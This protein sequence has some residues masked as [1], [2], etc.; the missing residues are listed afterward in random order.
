MRYADDGVHADRICDAFARKPCRCAAQTG[1]FQPPSNAITRSGVGGGAPWAIAF[2]HENV[3]SSA[4]VAMRNAR[5]R[6]EPSPALIGGR[7]AQE[8]AAVTRMHGRAHGRAVAG[9][10]QRNL[11]ACRTFAPDPAVHVGQSWVTRSSP[12]ATTTSP[13]AMPARSAGPPVARPFTTSPLGVSAVYIPSH[14]RG[15]TP[16]RPVRRRSSR[17]GASRSAG[18]NMFP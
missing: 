18:T 5:R 8:I 16:D 1:R 4:A 12:T 10:G 17:I 11:G 15:G 9:H 14:G 7:L 6:V 3:A 2:P 13:G